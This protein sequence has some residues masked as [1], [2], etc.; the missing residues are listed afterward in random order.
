MAPE[1][2]ESIPSGR[3]VSLERE[4]FPSWIGRGMFGY[5]N[6]GAF[7]D[8]GTPESFQA[9]QKFFQES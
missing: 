5:K 6:S 4:I 9:A 1:V 8:I 2:I 7:I 3:A